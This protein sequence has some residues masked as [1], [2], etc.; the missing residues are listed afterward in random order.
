MREQARG[1]ASRGG[2]HPQPNIALEP[3]RNS[4]R[5]CLAPAIARG[6]PPALGARGAEAYVTDGSHP[7]S[8][9]GRK[10][11]SGR[12]AYRLVSIMFGLTRGC[13]FDALRYRTKTGLFA[14]LIAMS[15]TTV[16]VCAQSRA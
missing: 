1:L 10:E 6:S 7:Y 16:S 13:D 3:T 5:S 2:G 11:Y 9:V 12:N 14:L 15:F 8:G 4:L